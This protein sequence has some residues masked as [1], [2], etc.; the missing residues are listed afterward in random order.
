MPEDFWAFKSIETQR[1]GGA[2]LHGFALA[3]TDSQAPDA[4]ACLTG[5]AANPR[6]SLPMFRQNEDA[7]HVAEVQR[8]IRAHLTFGGEDLVFWFDEEMLLVRVNRGLAGPVL[9]QSSPV[10]AEAPPYARTQRFTSN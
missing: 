4:W 1:V 10:A 2:A 9:W 5:R 8:I 7:P 6:G 3:A